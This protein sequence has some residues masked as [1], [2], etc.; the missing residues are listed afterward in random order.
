MVFQ[1]DMTNSW[2]NVELTDRIHDGGELKLRIFGFESIDEENLN[3]EPDSRH[4]GGRGIVWN[5]PSYG[6]SSS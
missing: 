2:K 3:K 1:R 6:R 4:G 5:R